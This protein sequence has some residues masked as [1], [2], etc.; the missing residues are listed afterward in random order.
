MQSADSLSNEEESF[1]EKLIEKH[2]KPMDRDEAKEKQIQYDL[3][4]L[5]NKCCLVFFLLNTFLVTLVCTLTQNSDYAGALNI[6]V[7]CSGN[8]FT[9]EPISITFT[10]VFGILLVVQFL[11]LLLHRTSTLIH[12]VAS[13]QINNNREVYSD[14]ITSLKIL[15]RQ[16][17]SSVLES[18][19]LGHTDDLDFAFSNGKGRK[20]KTIVETMRETRPKSLD[21]IVRKNLDRIKFDIVEGSSGFS[22]DV[23][24][25]RFKDLNIRTDEEKTALRNAYPKLRALYPNSSH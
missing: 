14:F 9:I 18:K 16:G 15:Q 19:P 8:V 25:Q 10:V 24:C 17:S 5:R 2:L 21:D 11:C 20:M 6:H 4:A 22:E 3:I 7:S 23:W 1:W 12:I 13:T